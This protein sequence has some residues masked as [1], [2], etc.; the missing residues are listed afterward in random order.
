M[1]ESQQQSDGLPANMLIELRESVQP[2]ATVQAGDNYTA[3]NQLEK[4]LLK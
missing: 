1:S 3:T 2:K 4:E